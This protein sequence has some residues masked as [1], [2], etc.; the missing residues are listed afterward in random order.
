MRQ[1]ASPVEKINSKLNN[2]FTCFE[3]PKSYLWIYLIQLVR[4]VLILKK[5][6]RE[7]RD[8]PQNVCTPL[9]LDIFPLKKSGV[10][11]TRTSNVHF[12][13]FFLNYELIRTFF[14]SWLWSCA[15]RLPFN[16]QMPIQHNKIIT[17]NSVQTVS[18]KWK[19]K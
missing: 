17:F 7:R 19:K 9:N 3:W 15:A 14:F 4:M 16:F 8:D 11:G 1:W 12:I 18:V 13:F 5:R 6:Q 2:R 10:D